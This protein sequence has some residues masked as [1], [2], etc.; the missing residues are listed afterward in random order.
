MILIFLSI[1]FL[2]GAAFVITHPVRQKPSYAALLLKLTW[3][4]AACSLVHAFV[5]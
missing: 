4:N 5:K 2:L 1:S 3:R